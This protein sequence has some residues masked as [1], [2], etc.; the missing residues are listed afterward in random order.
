MFELKG[1]TDEWFVFAGGEEDD[2]DAPAVLL[3]PL[4]GVQYNTYVGAMTFKEDDVAGT[5]TFEVKEQT[6][7]QI[8]R[9]GVINWRNVGKDGKEI[10]YSHAQLRL[11][12][13]TDLSA[14][15]SKI[16][17]LSRLSWG[18]AKNSP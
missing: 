10:P 18:T 12:N 6:M 5:A 7:D 4:D 15:A 11:L 9:A 17:D 1:I 2:A 8:L 13:P 16:L 14:I 3:H